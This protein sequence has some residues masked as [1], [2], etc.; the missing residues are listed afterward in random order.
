MKS[1]WVNWP[2]RSLIVSKHGIS[3]PVRYSACPAPC[4]TAERFIKL[5]I[6]ELKATP[7]RLTPP[8]GVVNI[9]TRARRNNESEGSLQELLRHAGKGGSFHVCYFWVMDTVGCLW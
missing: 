1:V 7:P 3:S 2:V 6:D 9:P 5:D 8:G 4:G